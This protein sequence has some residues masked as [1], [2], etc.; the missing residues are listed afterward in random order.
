MSYMQTK[1]YLIHNSILYWLLNQYGYV[2]AMC[3]LFNFNQVSDVSGCVS[4]YVFDRRY[5]DAY[6]FCIY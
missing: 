1:Y 5:N 3:L 4:S 6:V 2:L